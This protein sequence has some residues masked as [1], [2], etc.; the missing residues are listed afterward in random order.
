[1]YAEFRAQDAEYDEKMK[2]QMKEKS[3]KEQEAK[4]KK[5]PLIEELD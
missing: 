3:I 4:S 2:E 1:M 5:K